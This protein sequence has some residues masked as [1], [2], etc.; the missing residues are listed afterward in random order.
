M[1]GK[2][3]A[4]QR[5]S[6]HRFLQLCFLPT[7]AVIDRDVDTPDLAVAAPGDA[8]DLM[9]AGLVQP[10]AARGARDDGFRFASM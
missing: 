5:P 9:K 1:P 4:G 3:E 8:A 2:P 10:L 6:Q 7:L